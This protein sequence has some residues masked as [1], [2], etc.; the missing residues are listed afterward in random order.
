MN[1]IVQNVLSDH[2]NLVSVSDV[3]QGMNEVKRRDEIQLIIVDIDYHTEEAL[4]FIQHIKTSGLYRN[5][6]I[7]VLGSREQ[8][9]DGYEEFLKVDR[10]FFKP[11]SP[12]EMIRNIDE[13]MHRYSEKVI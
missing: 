12:E 8:W 2:F 6:Q 10:F 3:Y 5:K 4:G 7:V 13:L 9:A 1:F 11:F